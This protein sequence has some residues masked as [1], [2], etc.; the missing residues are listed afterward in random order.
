MLCPSATLSASK[1]VDALRL[2]SDGLVD[3]AAALT[4]SL[5]ELG[6]TDASCVSWT[7]LA[8]WLP[9]MAGI[10]GDA[11]SLL[12]LCLSSKEPFACDAID[13]EWRGLELI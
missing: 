3:E 11:G 8:L 5:V 4:G 13:T 1:W 6:L 9:V 2:S 7:L 10:F 12:E